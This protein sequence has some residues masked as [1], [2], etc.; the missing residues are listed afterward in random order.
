MKLLVS[1]GGTGGHLFPGIAVAEEFLVRDSSNE[2]LFIGTKNG[3]EVK[4]LP[5]LNYPHQFISISGL[6][7]KNVLEKLKTFFLIPYSII[8]SMRIIHR[9]KPDVVLGVGGYASFS[10]V[11]AS[12]L[13][14]KKRYIQEQNFQP[15]FTNK[16]LSYLVQTIFVSFED[17]KSFFPEE[18]VIVS[19]NPI[20]NFKYFQPLEH[21]IFTVFV[22]G[23]SQG[24]HS[25]NRAMMEALSFLAPLK[26]KIH[27]IHQTGKKDLNWIFSRY[28]ELGWKAEVYEFI[29]DIDRMYAKTDYAICRAGA[30][31][32]AELSALGKACLFIPY[33]HAV[34]NHQEHNAKLLERQGAARIL[35]DWQLTGHELAKEIQYALEHPHELSDMRKKIKS[36]SYPDAAKTIVDHFTK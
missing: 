33:P 13:L 34:H 23:G 26:N 21:D 11:F 9:F 20:R 29:D 24:A 7:G 15:G 4:I 3:I 2:V 27:I 22:F 8:Q 35:L 10:V 18:K 25:I 31:S 17:S 28:Q 36:F 1:G 30:S 12:F 19:G 14:R 6:K 5:K 16:I 32:V